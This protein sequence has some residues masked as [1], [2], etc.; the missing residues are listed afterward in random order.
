MTGQQGQGLERGHTRPGGGGG[1]HM[2]LE[3]E[4]KLD[5]SRGL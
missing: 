2:T 5:T 4:I 1:V 3:R